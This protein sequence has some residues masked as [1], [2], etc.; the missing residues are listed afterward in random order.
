MYTGRNTFSSLFGFRP[1]IFDIHENTEVEQEK[2]QEEEKPK[3]KSSQEMVFIMD[4]YVDDEDTLKKSPEIIKETIQEDVKVVSP[5]ITSNYIEEI[6]DSQEDVPR[7]SNYKSNSDSD[8]IEEDEKPIH[9][10]ST[11]FNEK[12]VQEEYDEE[13]EK[14]FFPTS[15]KEKKRK[16]SQSQTKPRKN[17]K[18]EKPKESKRIFFFILIF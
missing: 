8:I 1:L 11:K 4:S 17:K 9:K 5:E 6:I 16:Y 14:L 18:F 12:K 2:P 15:Q 10:F 3:E 7:M 13:F